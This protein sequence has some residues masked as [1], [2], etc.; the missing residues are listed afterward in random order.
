MK[1]FNVPLII[2][3]G[4]GYTIRNVAKTWTYETGQLVG[5]HLDENLPFNDYIQYFGPEYKLEVP[6]TSMDNKNS[7]EY[8]EAVQIGRAHV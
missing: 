4:G 6:S 5:Q 2:V 7:R 8:L 1:S 3:G